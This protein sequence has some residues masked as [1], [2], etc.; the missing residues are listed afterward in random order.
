MAPRTSADHMTNRANRAT[1]KIS[2]GQPKTKPP[3]P[4]SRPT[5]P[6][7]WMKPAFIMP[8]RAMNRPMPTLIATFSGEGTALKIAERKPVSTRIIRMKPSITTRPMASA[9]VIP[10]STTTP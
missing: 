4:S 9:Q 2:S 8:I 5:P 10:G 6:E 7:F 3:T 1:R